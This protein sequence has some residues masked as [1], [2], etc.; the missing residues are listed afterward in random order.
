MARVVALR[1][2]ARAAGDPMAD[3]CVLATADGSGQAEA[4]ALVVRGLGPG[5][6]DLMLSEHSPKYHALDAWGRYEVLLFWRTISVQVRLRGDFAD[7]PE[8]LRDEVWAR[9]RLESKL[10]DHFYAEVQPQSTA[11]ESRDQLLEGIEA[12]RERWPEAPQVPLAPGTRLLRLRPQ[13]VEGWRGSEGDRLHHRWE[14]TREGD[15]WT[16][17]LLVP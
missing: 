6:V 17:R 11:L 7:G 13:R 1:D 9:K 8:A 12:L 4:R 16:S 2:E 3:L 5:G 10:L 14:A 15:A